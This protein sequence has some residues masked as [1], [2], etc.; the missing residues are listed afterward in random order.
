MAAARAESILENQLGFGN[1]T[2]G[3]VLTLWIPTRTSVILVASKGSQRAI[4]RWSI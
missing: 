3:G 4:D 1:E 2:I